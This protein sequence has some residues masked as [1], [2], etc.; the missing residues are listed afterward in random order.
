MRLKEVRFAQIAVND[1]GE[2]FAL[3]RAGRLWF[4]GEDSATLRMMWLRWD[5]P[6]P[7]VSMRQP[8]IRE[9]SRRS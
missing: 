8:T 7:M 2:L 4:W 9:A 3:D 5:G 1:E 6:A